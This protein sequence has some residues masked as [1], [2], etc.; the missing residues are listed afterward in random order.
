MQLAQVHAMATGCRVTCRKLYA[1]TPWQDLPAAVRAIGGFGDTVVDNF[2]SEIPV[3]DLSKGWNKAAA[4]HIVIDRQCNDEAQGPDVTEMHA[5]GGVP[6]DRNPRYQPR[7]PARHTA[8]PFARLPED[9]DPARDLQP[10]PQQQEAAARRGEEVQGILDN[11]GRH[12]V[13]VVLGGGL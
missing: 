5:G 7:L 8:L 11:A 4:S 13:N 1:D 2:G 3:C 9:S 6:R 12:V 10:H